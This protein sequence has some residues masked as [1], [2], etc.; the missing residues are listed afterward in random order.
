MTNQELMAKRKDL[1]R[2]ANNLEDGSRAKAILL[3][4]AQQ[5]LSKMK[6]V[7]AEDAYGFL[8]H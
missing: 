6:N 1:L 3:D 5:Y 7:T 2:K 8:V 4:R